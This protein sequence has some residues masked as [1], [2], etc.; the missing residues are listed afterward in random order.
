MTVP[1]VVVID[2]GAEVGAY[3]VTVAT[4]LLSLVKLDVV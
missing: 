2:D 3:T 1:E 4:A